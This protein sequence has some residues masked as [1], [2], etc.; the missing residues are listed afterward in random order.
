[1]KVL[2]V[3]TGNICRSAM[4]GALLRRSLS[5]AGNDDIEIIS[6]GTWALDGAPASGIAVDVLAR[7]G[8]DLSSHRSRSL[9][10]DDLRS[11]DLV[12]AMTSVHVREIA[13][14]APGAIDKVVLLKELAEIR[15]PKDLG[16]GSGPGRLQALLEA[17]RPAARRALDVDDPM[18]LPATAYERCA[19]DLERGIEVLVRTLCGSESTEPTASP[20]GL[21]KTGPSRTGN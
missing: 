17:P 5:E 6:A 10:V 8:I 1:M 3:C 14:I 12:V 19:N 21:G 11:A 18:G 7:R 4:A 15:L 20:E 16:D 13:R 2:F 9:E